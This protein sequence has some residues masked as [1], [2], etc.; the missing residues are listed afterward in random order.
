MQTSEDAP[1]T[2]LKMTP[3]GDA[4]TN[5]ARPEG[6]LLSS[7]E[8][9]PKVHEVPGRSRRRT[10]LRP[11][12]K[13]RGAHEGT[14][15]RQHIELHNERRHHHQR[16]TARRHRGTSG[17][18]ETA[19]TGAGGINNCT[20]TPGETT[21]RNQVHLTSAEAATGQHERAQRRQRQLRLTLDPNY[22]N[23]QAETRQDTRSSPAAGPARQK[24]QH[25]PAQRTKH[26]R[27]VC[28]RR[29]T[30]RRRHL[31]QQDRWVEPVTDS[32]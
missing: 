9:H 30:H 24:S 14:T 8:V 6:R 7:R 29:R 27:P 15:C 25:L 28:H 10:S 16:N 3:E 23:A 32:S 4:P 21:P 19:R 11:V 2:G 31:K 13:P 18:T 12:R 22:V 1:S 5:E 17:A 20:P 26:H